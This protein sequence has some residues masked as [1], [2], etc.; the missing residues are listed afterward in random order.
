M[1]KTDDIWTLCSITRIVSMAEIVKTR[2]GQVY[3]SWSESDKSANQMCACN[4][5]SVSKIK[6]APTNA[7]LHKYGC[8]IRVD[9]KP[10]DCY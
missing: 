9:R 3:G 2:P 5:R 10:D 7:D 1:T 8:S 6:P 4:E